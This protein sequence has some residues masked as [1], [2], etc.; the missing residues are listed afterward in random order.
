[1]SALL[2]DFVSWL[3]EQRAAADRAIEDAASRG[4]PNQARYWQGRLHALDDALAAFPASELADE[5]VPL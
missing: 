5:T 2:L 1:M 4:K 3:H